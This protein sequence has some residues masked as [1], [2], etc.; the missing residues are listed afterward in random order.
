M[1]S[2]VRAAFVAALAT[3]G[4]AALLTVA[5]PERLRRALDRPNDAALD[6]EIDADDLTDAEALAMLREL[7]RDLDFDDLN[8]DG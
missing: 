2:V 3:A 8:A 6:D 7:A 1:R 5:A 4:F